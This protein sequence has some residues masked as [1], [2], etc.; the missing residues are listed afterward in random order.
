[1]SDE[2]RTRKFRRPWEEPTPD[3][4]EQGP[5]DPEE[6]SEDTAAANDDA[7]SSEESIDADDAVFDLF[8]GDY[9]A[10]TTSEYRDLAEEISRAHTEE[11]ERQ[12]VAAS[13]PGVGSGLIGFEDVTGQKGLSEEDVESEEQ[14]RA[15]D[16][17][18]RVASAVVL[19]GLFL[20]SLLMGGAWFS[21]FVTIV[22][23]VALGEFYATVRT[24]GFSPAAIFGF[25]GLIGVAIGAHRAGPGAI[26]GWIGGAVIAVA[27]FY[28]VAPRRDPLGNAAITVFGLAWISMLA[29][30]IVI[31]RG[32]SAVALILLVVGVTAL[33]DMGAYF[34]GR[35]F[36]KRPLAPKVSPKKTVEGLMGGV[37][38]AFGTTLILSTIP[39][40]EPLDLTGALALAA[41]ISVLAP[42]GDAAES[43]VKRAL[44]TKD[45]GS[46]LPGHGG[47][48]DRIDALLFVAPAAFFLFDGL[49]YL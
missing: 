16:L 42:L 7:E 48:L 47:M 32:E 5:D 15:S 13:M 33:F 29:F 45:M 39:L 3:D 14:K 41:I 30:A 23:V 22:M 19:I 1:L 27:F 46:I 18:L 12:A 31:A 35:S 49:G 25:L 24:R 10:A 21:T 37:I 9:V 38:T 20:G 4:P 6:S 28:A 40:F 2:D 17:T 34:V 43:V 11:Y 8:Q 26:G 44:D 36:G